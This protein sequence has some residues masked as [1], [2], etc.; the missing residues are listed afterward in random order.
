METNETRIKEWMRHKPYRHYKTYLKLKVMNLAE[1]DDV[2]HHLKY[3]VKTTL[4]VSPIHG[5]GVF[6][7]RNIQ[8]GEQLFPIWEFD[9]GIYVIPNHRLSELPNEVYK[10]L[11]M[12][13]INEDF[14]YKI[15]RLFKGVNLLAHMISY[16]NSVYKT[17]YIQNVS[18]NGIALI[19]IK[20]GEEILESYDENINLDN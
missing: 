6:A 16:C 11:D 3:N 4:G 8:K 2:I 14:G 9:S 1:L 5:I 12:Y 19:D 13:F 18:N 17:K 7:I 20:A 15:I 10:L